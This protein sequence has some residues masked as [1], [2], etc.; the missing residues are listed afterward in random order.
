M[1]LKSALIVAF[2]SV[3]AVGCNAGDTPTETI[4]TTNVPAQKDSVGGAIQANPNMPDAAKKAL[5]G[6]GAKR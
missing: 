2:L 5:M 1:N 4:K 6:G 3:V